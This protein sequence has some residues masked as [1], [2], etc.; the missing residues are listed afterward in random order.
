M[1][2]P[3]KHQRIGVVVI[4]QSPRP[5]DRRPRSPPCCRPASQ[6]ELRGALDGMSR[7]EIDAIPPMDGDDTLFT[8]LPN[9]DGVTHQQEG[10]RAPRRASS[11]P[12][13]STRASASR[14]WPA[15]ASFPISRPMACVHPA[16]GRFCI[17]LVEAVLPKGRLGVFSPLPEQTALIDQKWQRDGVEVV[18]VTLQSRLGRCRGRRGR[19]DDGRARTRPRGDGLHELHQRQQGARAHAYPGPVIL[20]IAAAARVVEEL[21]LVS[22]AAL[23]DDQPRRHRIAR[24]RRLD[25]RHRR[26]RQ[27]L[28]RPAQHARAL[29]RG[30][31]RA[32]DAAARPRRRRLGRRRLQ[33]GRAAGRP[34]AADRQPH[35]RARRRADGGAS[36]AASSAP[37]CA[38]RS[39]AATACSR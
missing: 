19:A 17:A 7:A 11:S 9:G 18:G 39:A 22:E 21:V 16:V 28:S 1:N 24:R 4:G 34:G 30:P 14:C 31:S 32:A 38:S 6:I 23:E 29:R 15:P 12:A 33:H 27:S 26:R 36:S 20:A 35:H 13:S 37:S 2:K 3:L 25:P 8:L 10:G 5:T